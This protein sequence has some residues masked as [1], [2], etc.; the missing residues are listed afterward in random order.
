MNRPAHVGVLTSGGDAP[1]MNAAI[2]AVVRSALYNDL[3]ITG[4]IEG[5]DGMVNGRSMPLG[6]RDVSNIIQ[7]GGTILRSARSAAFR[8]PEGRMRA[9]AHLQEQGIDAL[10]VIGGDGTFA[11]AKVFEQE[12][13]MP[14]IGLPGTIDNDLSGTDMTIGFDTA[15]NTAVEAIDKIRDT[16]SSHDRLFFVEVMGRDTGFIA[17]SAALAAGAEYVMLPEERQTIDELVRVLEEGSRTKSSSIVVVAEGDEEGGALTVAR[18][19]KE[20]FD[21]YD[22]RV[23]VLGHLQRGGAPT[24][25][26]RV[27]AS[28]LGVAAVEQLLNGVHGGMLG[29]VNDQVTFTP[30]DIAINTRKTPQHDLLR[31]QAILSI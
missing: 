29:L 27:L 11:G 1:G 6:S 31:V 23:T 13:G 7:R 2:R 19:V 8:T 4:I 9:M 12:H 10:V 20:R 25:T 26:D 21:H 28:R 22:I 14:V 15:T 5:F 24:V 17:M 3:R 18:K 30:F 16:A